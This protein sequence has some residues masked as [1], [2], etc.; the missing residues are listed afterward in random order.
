M[1]RPGR[2][3]RA[4]LHYLK[5]PIRNFIPPLLGLAILLIVGSICFHKLYGQEELTYLRAFYITYCRVGS[6]DPSV[7]RG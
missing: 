4:Y 2:R 1:S 3:F 6:T 5:R 7:T